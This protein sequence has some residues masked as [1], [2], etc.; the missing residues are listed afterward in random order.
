MTPEHYRL[1]LQNS[2]GELTDISSSY[3]TY[4]LPTRW[5]GR[6]GTFFYHSGPLR[7][8]LDDFC[9]DIILHEQE[10]F[11]IGGG[12]IARVAKAR[13]IPLVVFVNEN[14]HRA[15]ILPRRWLR[16]YVLKRCAGL[17]AISSGAAVVHRDWGFA[18]PI[19]VLAQMGVHLNPTPDF[20]ARTPGTLRICYAG[21]LTPE[22][23][24]DLLMRAIAQ[25]RDKD[26]PIECTVAGRGESREELNALTHSLGIQ[27]LVR[28]TGMLLPAQVT[29]LLQTN[30]VLV[31]P[32]RRTPTWEEQ[33]GRILVEAMAHAVVTS[34]S[35]TGAIPEVIGSDELLFDE[36]SSDGLMRVLERLAQ[37]PE[38]ART[39]RRRL[40][41][42][43]SEQY[44]THVLTRRRVTFLKEIL[45]SNRD[46]NPQLQ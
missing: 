10:V 40:W 2:S 30:D 3:R 1:A 38:F 45:Q 19:A 37:D 13:G 28:F 41:E 5:G 26:I 46:R 6:Q 29:E 21:R 23:G 34:G 24:V 39:Q 12:Q 42:K 44:E 8:A 4:P 9:P 33:F 43:A 17:I 36:D 18:G 32:S 35:R 22:K 7:R 16:D 15:L 31:L 27:N 25:L 11:A 20:E 14:I